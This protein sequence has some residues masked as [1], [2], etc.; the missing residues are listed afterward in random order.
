MIR[1][2]F[3]IISAATLFACAKLENPTLRQIENVKLTQISIDTVH[4]S[5]EAR[6]YNP[7]RFG[8]T[9]SSSQI[10][11]LINEVQ[12]GKIQQKYGSKIKGHSEFTLP[13]ELEFPAEQLVSNQ[14]GLIK[15]ILSA[16][17]D[18][19]IEVGFKGE[20]IMDIL[21]VEF[22]IPINQVEEVPFK[23]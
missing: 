17:L 21:S 10:E 13:L 4:L 2:L 6:F 3:V 14:K 12:M 15:G 20:V 18:Q 16:L 23:L 22:A 9:V 1:I 7:N 11:V 8:G 5:A 19:K